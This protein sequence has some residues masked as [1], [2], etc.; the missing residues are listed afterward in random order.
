M[1]TINFES[2]S[3]LRIAV[4]HAQFESIHP[5]LGGNGRLGR[6]LIALMAQQENIMTTPIFFVSEELEKERQ[7]YYNTLNE[8]RG[9]SPTWVNWIL[10]FLTACERTA[11]NLL[12]KIESAQ[13]L[14]EKGMKQCQTDTQL[15]VWL[16]TLNNPVATVSEISS[17]VQMHHATVR[18]ARDFLVEK[19][20]LEKDKYAKR[21]IKYFNYDII[22]IFH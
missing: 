14:S 10:F 9:Q 6:I 20:F 3:L 1:E 7:R 11:I 17:M 2:D 4:A 22:R 15:K 21:N 18:K 13:M 12:N 8:I 19:G 16:A 5:F